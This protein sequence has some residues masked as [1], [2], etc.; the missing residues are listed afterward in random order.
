M[1][2]ENIRLHPTPVEAEEHQSLSCKV[3]H[4]KCPDCGRVISTFE[5]SKAAWCICGL[6]TQLKAKE[7]L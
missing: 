5:L 4:A 3:Y 1:P 2:E 6:S 7:G